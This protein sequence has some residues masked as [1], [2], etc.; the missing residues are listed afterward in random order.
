MKVKI[1]KIFLLLATVVMAALCGLFAACGEPEPVNQQSIKYDGYALTW[2]AVEGANGYTITVNGGKE[3]SS[4][5][6]QFSYPAAS[7]DERIEVTIVAKNGDAAAAPTT[8]LFTRLPKIEE[9][10]I[11]FDINGKMSWTQVPGAMEYI[12]EIN[13]TQTRTPALEYSAFPQGQT[14]T[15]RIKPVAADDSSFSEWSV[16]LNKEY[17]APPSAIKYDGQFITWS[18]SS[19]AQSY[20][21]Y[22][23]GAQ[24][25]L[26]VVGASFEYNAQ[27]SS[28]DLQIQAIGNGTTS[29]SSVLS[30]TKRYVWLADIT[31][32]SVENGILSWNAVEEATGYMVKVNDKA[33]QFVETN[34]FTD[35]PANKSNVITVKPVIAETEGTTTFYSNWSQPQN[36]RILEAPD[37]KWN[38]GQVLDGQKMNVLSWDLITGDVGGYNV[39]VVDPNGVERIDALGANANQYG[40]EAF[41]ITG[42]YQISIQTYPV[43]NS[44]SYHSQYSK[45]ISV[46]RLPAPN[47]VQNWVTSTANNVKEGFN[48]QWQAVSGATGYQLYKESEKIKTSTTAN[49]KVN[50]SD[51][52]S[53]DDTAQKIINFSVQSIGSVKTF[54]TERKVTLSSLT[55]QSLKTTITVLGQPKDLAIN[56][57]TA[58][59]TTDT[60]ASGYSV[61]VGDRAYSS[62]GTYDLSNLESGTYDF[63]VCANG[64]GAEI[65]ASNYTPTKKIARLA[66]PIN[67]RIDTSDPQR[68]S[69]TWDNVIGEVDHYD[70]YFS[71]TPAV[72]MNSNN[73][74]QI[75]AQITTNGRGVNV[76]A[77]ANEWDDQGA[78][79][80]M[81]SRPSQ[82]VT[83]TKMQA[84]TFNNVKVNDAGNLTWNAPANV[85]GVTI[86]YRVFDATN[87][88][89]Y[90]GEISGREYPLTGLVGGQSYKYKVKAIG[91]ANGKDAFFVSSDYSEEAAFTKL[92][93]PE[94]KAFTNGDKAY[95]WNN[96]GGYVE[97]YIVKINGKT[98]SIPYSDLTSEYTYAPNFLTTGDYSVEIYAQGDG[99]TTIDSDSWK[100]TQKVL[101]ADAPTFNISYCD[102]TGAALTQRATNGQLL[103]TVTNPARSTA[104]YKVQINND[105]KRDIAEGATELIW[106]EPCNTAGSYAVKVYA[107]GGVFDAAGN[108]YVE[109]NQSN[110]V[111]KT[112]TIL[113]TPGNVSYSTRTGNVECMATGEDLQY[114]WT[115]EYMDS[116]NV[117]QTKTFTSTSNSTNL[118]DEVGETVTS[119]VNVKVYVSNRYGNE[120]VISST[121]VSWK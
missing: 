73:M 31:G 18:G 65:L 64:N 46:T 56:G 48:L 71:D 44:N 28:F 36:V 20:Q 47:A 102:S 121:E 92:K 59:W 81:T 51:F 80:W 11:T 55:S 106:M 119:V 42:T 116:N 90:S 6:N 99:E 1:K 13:G 87:G 108:Y 58:S 29:F 111:Q 115:V 86:R 23:N 52:M 5:T 34:S 68:D 22:I 118:V 2:D 88:E 21:V 17:L 101:Y 16:Q 112:L 4:S 100:K 54:G 84:P 26:P 35:I 120:S 40:N 107:N 8:K 14:N 83:F 76:C 74:A 117:K 69:I 45:P 43:E 89:Q 96:V 63:G 66:S 93:T 82:T 78:V 91:Q 9:A 39:K 10:N 110:V 98:D 72:A 19:V 103:V 109:T 32:F 67:V 61:S 62:T 77:V 60:S 37:L 53:E 50:Y 97:N 3:Y 7:T 79:Y 104:G 113:Q 15:I 33:A 24:Q 25:G 105:I 57:Y 95:K 27:N 70:V 30:E 41:E 75:M 12:L 94:I 85:Q 49:I 114:N 38:E